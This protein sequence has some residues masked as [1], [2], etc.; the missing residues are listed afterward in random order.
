MWPDDIPNDEP[1]AAAGID[2]NTLNDLMMRSYLLLNGSKMIHVA[3]FVPWY[4]KYITPSH[5]GVATEWQTV[6]LLSAYNAFVDAD[7]CCGIN[8]FSNAAFYQHYPLAARY[9]QNDPP[10]H[11]DLVSMGFIDANSGEVIPKNYIRY[12][13]SK[14]NQSDCGHNFSCILLAFTLGTMTA[15][16]GSSINSAGSGTI[17]T[18]ERYL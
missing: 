5:D 11:D 8:T 4:F 2:Y 14:N 15:L 12:Y 3:G 6:K 16:R 7:A 10:T 18:E 9:K 1:S 17:Q 13:I